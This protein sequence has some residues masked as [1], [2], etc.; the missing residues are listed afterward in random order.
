MFSPTKQMESDLRKLHNFTWDQLKEYWPHYTSAW[1]QWNLA[2]P[3]SCFRHETVEGY[4]EDELY[5]PAVVNPG[6]DQLLPKEEW[7]VSTIKAEIAAGRKA[8]IYV[9]QT[10]TRDIR[11]RLVDVLT[12]AGIPGVAMLKS[13]ITPSKREAWLKKHPSNVLITNPRLVETGLDLVQFSTA[14]FY[15]P[16]YSLYTMWQACRRVWRL[17]QTKPV[18]VYYLCYA[19]TLESKAYALIGQKIKAAQLLYGDEVSSALVDDPGDASL[20]MALI[21]A[22]KNNEEVTADSNMK[23]FSDDRHV[24]IDSAVG[25]LTQTSLSVFE[26]W[27]REQGYAYQEIKPQPR[28]RRQADVSKAQMALL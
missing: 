11:Q 20:V 6:T 25:S 5:C 3:N 13:S 4:D 9:R 16:D 22:I 1:L 27:A 18:K 28:R 17:G 21:K 2:R 12:S 10:G 19:D 8:V 15:E 14:I 7:L 24:V 23:L 26:K